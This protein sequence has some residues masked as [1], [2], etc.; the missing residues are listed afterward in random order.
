MINPVFLRTF[1]SLAETKSFTK[2]ANILHMTQPGVS[3]H[4]KWLEDYFETPLIAREGK[5]FELTDQG[6]KLLSYGVTLFDD[7]QQFKNSLG[8]DDP[9]AGVCRFASPG[10]FGIK[11]YSFL[12]E[13]NKRHP[14][15][16]MNYSYAPNQ[17]IVR[18]VLEDR[19]DI[20]FVTRKP[21]ESILGVEI[22]EEEELRLIVP[23]KFSDE[24]FR[25][26]QSLGFI[27]HPDGFHHASRL[28][29]E[30]FPKDFRGM[31]E[32]PLRGFINQITRILEP[33]SMGLGFT[34]L[35]EFAYN[36]FSGKPKPK[37]FPLK[38]SVTDPVYKIYK[39]HRSL[40]SR[41][42]F[43]FEEYHKNTLRS[44]L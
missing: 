44:R 2:T 20:G 34:A 11:M 40:P 22:I 7:H 10:S 1:L 30:N 37:V 18:D 23:A 41:F 33:V 16:V 9:H 25:G 36:S 8:K 4:L 12:L 17:T 31:Q 26:L 43:I 27:N 19:V 32:F 42:D 38:K 35:P 13:L 39:K 15:L 28:L 6:R 3:Q 21:E 14:K 24:S 5:Q 29:Q